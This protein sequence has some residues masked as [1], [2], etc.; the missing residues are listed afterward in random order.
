MAD[1]ELSIQPPGGGWEGGAVGEGEP[2]IVFNTGQVIR[3]LVRTHR[4]RS[5]ARSHL[6]H[7][8]AAQ[9]PCWATT[10]FIDL[11]LWIGQGGQP[12]SA[13]ISNLATS[14]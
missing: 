1:W 12:R 5:P 3:G 6:G 2:A 11:L 14:G 13:E 10:Y 9:I 4:G 8:C 7:L